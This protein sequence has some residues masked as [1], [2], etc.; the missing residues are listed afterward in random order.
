MCGTAKMRRLAWL[1]LAALGAGMVPGYGQD[2]PEKLA[3]DVA[4]DL[5]N[6]RLAAVVA[7]FTPEMASGLPL[8]TLDRVWSGVLQQGGPVR[9]LAPARLVQVTGAGVA[10]VIVPIRLERIAL[11]LKISIAREH[12]AGFFIAP[13]APPAQSWNAPDYLDA[14]KF[15]NV[16]VTVGPTALGGTLSLPKTA[17]RAPAVV[18][19]HGSGPNDRDETIGPNRPFRD[20]AEGLA[21]RGV[22]ALRY[23]K[24]TKVHPEQFAGS[25]TVREE[26]MDDAIAAVALL[27]ARPEID[28][29]RIVVVGHSLGGTLAPRIAAG[30]SDI[31]GVVILAGATRPL[32]L[33]M[34]EQVEYIASLNG[35]A[36]EATQ[37]RI[38]AIK[39]EAAR[40]M[41]AKASDAGAKILGVPAAYWAD[42]NAYDPATAAA[43]LTQPLLILQGGRDYQVTA[44]DLQRFKT[45][46]AGRPN[47]TIREFPRLNHL[48]MSGDGKSR[49]EEYSKA[50]HVDAE[51]IEAL[52]GFVAGLPK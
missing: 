37:K 20:I 52:A 47:V 30:R 51:V 45:A 28:A 13:S 46:L 29:R 38:E 3:T 32:P 21:S 43:Q 12:V 33:I 39:A 6:H 27:A 49:P 34:V 41:A 15:T 50:G 10:L 23:D 40:A 14:A 44:D 24:R 17:G 5:V 36:D 9:E 7:R 35:P 4:N 31:A 22:A 1:V 26:T 2:S 11:D 42:L 16:D 18:L 19:I 48:F 8:T 25:S